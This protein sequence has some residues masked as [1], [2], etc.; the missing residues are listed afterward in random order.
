[1]KLLDKVKIATHNIINNKSR[2]ILTII[3]VT[4]VATLIMALS[5]FGILFNSNM[6]S[7]NQR[8]LENEGASYYISANY[9]SNDKAI[10][11]EELSLIENTL[12]KYNEIVDRISYVYSNVSFNE[13]HNIGYFDFYNYSLENLKPVSGRLWTKDDSNT[14]NIWLSEEYYEALKE[15]RDIN[16]GDKIKLS[17]NN[18]DKLI[19]LSFTISGVID[20]KMINSYNY[21]AIIDSLYIK[22]NLAFAKVDSIYASFIPKSDYSYRRVQ[23]LMLE[24]SREMKKI[25]P[26]YHNQY[27]EV[28]RFSNSFL[29]SIEASR[30]I[31]SLIIALLIILSV[32]VLLLSI[33]SI[34][35]TI[36]ISVDKNK[37]FI[38]LLKA[39]GLDDRNIKQIALLEAFILM[40]SG[41]L[42]ATI[43]MYSAITPLMSSTLALVLDSILET[44]RLGYTV[45]ALMPIYLPFIVLIIFTLLAVA[46]TRGS[47]KRISNEDTIETISEVA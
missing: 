44:S 38:G 3:I 30:V 18:A 27:G 26:A 25:I 41:L 19:E 42:I 17:I 16:I 21:S 39:L 5:S 45:K 23:S 34:C 46:F 32:V 12:N 11:N 47:L 33:G 29:D 15:N 37:R 36:I 14:N 40:F 7:V 20:T 31:G 4:I 28:D 10:S 8:K 24:L 35:N 1:M 6:M 13:V 22:N 2:S 9:D 43:L